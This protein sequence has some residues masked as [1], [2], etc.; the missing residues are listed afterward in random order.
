MLILCRDNAGHSQ[1][2]AECHRYR[3][4]SLADADHGDGVRTLYDAAQPAPHRPGRRDQSIDHLDI[5]S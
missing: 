2:P 4:I 5:H 3:S 1:K